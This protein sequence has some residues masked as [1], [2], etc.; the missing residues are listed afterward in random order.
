MRDIL[1]LNKV[2]A[3]RLTVYFGRHFAWAKYETGFSL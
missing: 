1:I 2:W 3:Q